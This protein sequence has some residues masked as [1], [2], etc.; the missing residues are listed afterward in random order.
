MGISE[1]FTSKTR[2]SSSRSVGRSFLASSTL[3]LTLRKAKSMSTPVLNSTSISDSPSALTDL[4]FFSPSKP[5]SLFS[6]LMVTAVS[7]SP[8]ATPR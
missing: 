5:F 2:G 1:I 4:R 8:G 3:S 7:T 6:I